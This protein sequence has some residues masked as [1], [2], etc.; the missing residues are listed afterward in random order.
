VQVSPLKKIIVEDLNLDNWPDLVL[1]GNDYSYDLATG[2][3]DAN[4]GLV[5]LNKGKKQKSGDSYFNVLPAS[6]SGI[7][8]QGMVESMLYFKGDTSLVVA[9]FNRAKTKVFKLLR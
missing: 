7:L 1:G 6:K 3:F 2:Y 4:K 5:L 8:L 9:G